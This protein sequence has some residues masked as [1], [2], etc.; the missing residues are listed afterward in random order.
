MSEKFARLYPKKETKISYVSSSAKNVMEVTNVLIARQKWL[1]T[2]FDYTVLPIFIEE[3]ANN[4][5]PLL[6]GNEYWT[7]HISRLLKLK[8]NSLQQTINT[9]T[10]ELYKVLKK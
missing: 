6:C 10:K 5:A 3:P 1:W 4:N 8:N 7:E 9:I 2:K